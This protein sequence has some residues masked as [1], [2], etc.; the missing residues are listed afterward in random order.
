M[1]EDRFGLTK[2]PFQLSPDALFFF[3][4]EEHRRALSFLQYG[5]RRTGMLII[6]EVTSRFV[7]GRVAFRNS[8]QEFG[9]RKCNT[10]NLFMNQSR[11]YL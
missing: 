5:L 6:A 11:H 1:Y 4:S 2:K 3:P 10:K 7:G 9:F 8:I